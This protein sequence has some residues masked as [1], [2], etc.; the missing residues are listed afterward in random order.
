MEKSNN[1]PGE[2][3]VNDARQNNAAAPKKK[4]SIFAVQGWNEI[5]AKSLDAKDASFSQETS[6][7]PVLPST[8]VGELQKSNYQASAEL[9]PNSLSSVCGG[10]VKGANSLE[11]AENIVE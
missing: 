4:G 2:D 11:L 9:G 8:F 6:D 10:N 1:D 3:A 5:V 7:M